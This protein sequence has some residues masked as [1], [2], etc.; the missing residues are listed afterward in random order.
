MIGSE[1]FDWLPLSVLYAET[2]YRFR[3]FPFSLYYRRQPEIIFDAPLR[4]EPDQSLPVTLLIKD[5][6]KFPVE[7]A[8]VHLHAFLDK[9]HVDQ[10]FDL[11]L[12]ISDT[13][14]HRI[15][16]LDV[17]GLPPGRLSLDTSVT[18]LTRKGKHIRVRQ[19]NHPGLSHKPLTVMKS[20]DPLPN[21]PNWHA[22]E[23]HCHT[24][25]GTDQ[26]EFGAPLQSYQRT[27]EAMGLGWVALTDHSY[28]LDDR[29][30]SYLTDDPGVPKWNLLHKEVK[31]LNKRSSV[32]LL[33]GE[34]LSCRSA[35]GRNI[36][37]L[38]IGNPEFLHG[39][40]DDAQKWLQTKSEH[41]VEEAVKIV[42][43]SAFIAAGHP[44]VKIPLLE[45][46][47][48]NR[49]EWKKSDLLDSGL[50]GWQ[51]LNGEWGCE[52]ERG[53]KQWVKALDSGKRI[54]IYA[55]NDAHGNFNRFRQVRL[56]MIKLWE[57]DQH[58]FGKVTTRALVKGELTQSAIIA[59]LKKGS[60]II[61]D[62]PAVELTVQQN[63]DSYRCGDEIEPSKDGE[64][65]VGYKTTTEFGK[66]KR[67]VLHSF[68]NQQELKIQD[69]Y[70][71]EISVG[72][73]GK[74]Y[75]RV[76][77]HSE[78]K[79]GEKHHAYTNPIWIR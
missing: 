24:S 45:R 69:P 23:L 59:S 26:V 44:F 17:S 79:N 34:E 70:E 10:T 60:A 36:H 18:F 73:S 38:I 49:G 43:D 58:L 53:L 77:F 72:V 48:V 6:D 39:S 55:G 63:D 29:L 41:S 37:M 25:Y 22:G 28:N 30:D 54:C 4:I 14:W 32:V 12:T 47:L 5:A 65:T 76:E 46:L 68:N 67:I 16:E 27:A 33:P 15:F 62:G 11:N 21:F 9:E 8:E 71:G 35:D 2:H 51:M 52:F 75:L 1:I 61:S 50:D 56:P 42:N 40:G 3:L 57:K 74:K 19:D 7:L 66:A 13:Y 20:K 64:I 31:R 78:I